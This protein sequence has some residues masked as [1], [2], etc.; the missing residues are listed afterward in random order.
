MKRTIYLFVVL[1]FSVVAWGQQRTHI[2]K[3]QETL[4]RIALRYNVTV[5]ELYRLNPGAENGISVGQELRIPSETANDDKR[6]ST[7]H[8]VE[9]GETLYSI[10]RRY[11]VSPDDILAANPKLNK[12]KLPNGV[13]IIIPPSRGNVIAEKAPENVAVPETQRVEE[14]RTEERR[15]EEKASTPTSGTTG[16]KTYVVPVGQTI[17][18]ICRITGW[19]EAQLYH[20]NPQLREGLRV[21]MTILLPDSTVYD[22]LA[23]RT[24]ET[25][26]SDD[27]VKLPLTPTMP[28][29][30]I[31]LA[32]P[33]SVDN[34]N[35]F[36]DY[37]EGFLLAL[38]DAKDAGNNVSLY[39]Y[40][41]SDD[42]LAEAISSIESLGQIDYII[43][44]VSDHSIE[45]LGQI[46]GKKSS[47]YVIPFTSK[48]YKASRLSSGKILQ[49]NTPH[50]VMHKV[51]AKKFV[52]EYRGYHVCIVKDDAEQ[53][54]KEAFITVLKDHL[55]RERIPYE[56]I[57][58]S[59]MIAIPE[60][61]RL[62]SAHTNTVL[63]PLSATVSA[64][65]NVVTPVG[66]AVDSLGISNITVFGH[67]EWQTY[68]GLA[69]RFAQAEATFYSSFHVNTTD[70]T[71]KT[72]QR[73]F[74]T[75]FGHGLGNTYPKYSILGYDTGRYILFTKPRDIGEHFGESHY[76]GVQSRFYFA[77]DLVYPNFYHNNGV[78]FVKY[79]T[80]RTISRR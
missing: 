68:N 22:N 75:W 13:I 65:S 42:K 34:G 10:A 73:E 11:N 38:K 26:R 23:I 7:Y 61:Q 79:N 1:L 31:V 80:D 3:P 30:Q 2:V 58:T 41:C 49:V 71:Y 15:T 19:S 54:R 35:R 28:P 48:E 39:V 9:K 29:M 53:N 18:N 21:G 67:P 25:K 40:D 69:E 77:P 72:F 16:L 33:F 47:T 43:G 56:E 60:I 24:P 66:T 20:Y 62:S 27:D 50:E 64:A 55:T 63:I 5:A 6:K 14:K 59:G 44:G 36:S 74:V 76:S 78:I 70:D 46:S 37:Y 32:L 4:Y 17:Y 8:A 57:N 51:T 45:R 12:D 52:E